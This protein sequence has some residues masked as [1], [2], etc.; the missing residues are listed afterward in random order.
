MSI[1]QKYSI[2]FF[3]DKLFEGFEYTLPEITLNY[4]ERISKQVGSNDYKK[5]PIFMK[6]KHNIMYHSNDGNEN[7]NSHNTEKHE[8]N[9]S[10]NFD[11][12]SIR[13]FQKTNLNIHKEGLHKFY[14]DFR[15]LL[16]KLTETNFD[17]IILDIKQ[18]LQILCNGEEYTIQDIYKIG[19]IIF[20]IASTNKFYSATYSKLW[21][22][23]I[24]NFDIMNLVFLKHKHQFKEL[25]QDFDSE[26]SIYKM[27]I[28]TNENY[29]LL[30]EYNLKHEKYIAFCH[31]FSCLCKEGLIELDEIMDIIS[32]NIHFISTKIN[33]PNMKKQ[34]E[35][36]IEYIYTL[37][38]VFKNDS[39][40]KQNTQHKENIQMLNE[41]KKYNLKTFCSFSNKIK[42][43]C[44]DIIDM[45]Q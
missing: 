2:D 34:C 23:L 20:E 12:N 38:E 3:Y 25:L 5:T 41:I 13:N 28:H 27:S 15:T 14:N 33:I 39:V 44:M 30:C 43:K 29:D 1:L 18:Q 8:R 21:K 4:I 19:E 45:F 40:V 9:H 16:N 10:N 17:T 6:K 7:N 31:F 42:F 32:G 37:Y 35:S 24:H 26:N 22:Y 11:W 36:C